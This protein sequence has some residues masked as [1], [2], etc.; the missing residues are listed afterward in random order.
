MIYKIGLMN[1]GTLGVKQ[2]KGTLDAI[3]LVKETS[4]IIFDS[5]LYFKNKRTPATLGNLLKTLNPVIDKKVKLYDLFAAIMEEDNDT[6]FIPIIHPN[7][8]GGYRKK[9][10]RRYKKPTKRHR[11]TYTTK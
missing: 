4:K 11:K 1:N 8:I 9:H 2:E 5:K 6:R 3:R 10:T 7:I